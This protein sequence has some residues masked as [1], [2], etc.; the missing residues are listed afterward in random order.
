[1]RESRQG[2]CLLGFKCPGSSLKG[3]FNLLGFDSGV[4]L[5]FG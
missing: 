5:F 1:M 4:L 2:E 3:E